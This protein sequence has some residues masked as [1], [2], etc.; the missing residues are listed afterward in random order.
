[1]G[2]ARGTFGI[3]E[4]CEA[5][6]IRETREETGILL[7]NHS[8]AGLTND[9]HPP[10]EKHY[11]SIFM[12]VTLAESASPRLCKPE[13]IAYWEWFTPSNLPA[14]LFAPLETFLSGAGYGG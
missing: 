7:Q 1:V 14:P 9:V 3:G 5:C 4:S 13:K 10:I 2:T 6:A 11:I 8:F 12:K